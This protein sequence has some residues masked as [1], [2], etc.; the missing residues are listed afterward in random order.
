L[1]E[2]YGKEV[3]F[4]VGGGLLKHGHD[5]TENCRHFLA[6]VSNFKYI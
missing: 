6:M 5:L 4:L 1:L 2:V 3:I